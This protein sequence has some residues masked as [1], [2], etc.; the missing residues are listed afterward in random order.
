ML[1]RIT[2][3][4]RIAGLLFVCLLLGLG[5]V[6][7]FTRATG[8]AAAQ[9]PLTSEPQSGDRA[10]AL[11]DF[12]IRAGLDRSLSAPPP[13]TTETASGALAPVLQ[14]NAAPNVPAPAAAE[15]RFSSLTRTP[16]KL[17]SLRGTLTPPRQTNAEDNAL[18]TRRFLKANGA[19]FRLSTAEV[20]GLSVARH[21]EDRHNGAAHVTLAQAVNGIEVFQG[22]FTAH[23]DRAGALVAA[24]GELM[25]SLKQRVNRA[26]PAVS[27]SEAVRLASAYAGVALN[28][29]LEQAQ[30]ATGQNARQRF[31]DTAALAR[32]IEAKLVYFPLTPDE[33]RLAWQLEFWRRDTQDVYLIMLDAERGS[34]LYRRNLTWREQSQS[35]PRGQVYTKDSPRPGLPQG[36][37]NPAVV[38]R[39]ELAFQP[40]P[41]NGQPVFAATDPH[42][43][44]WAGGALT[45][46][47]SNNTDTHLDRD[48]NNQP[49]TPRLAAVNGN[50]IFP[51]DL[52]KAPTE[53]DNQ[54]AAQANLFYWVN[55][56]HDIMYAYGFTEAAGNFQ[57]NNFNL[58]GRAG[59]PI[60]AQA[61]DGGG[62]N[63]ANFS[64]GA[65]GSTARVQM[66]LW[67][68]SPQIDGSLDQGIII[69]EL[70][71]GLSIRLV[72][73]G[74]GLTGV[75]GGG[76]GEGWSDYFGLVLLRSAGDDLDASY[77]VGQ[78]A[79]NNYRLGIRR[80]PYSTDRNIFPLTFGDLKLSTEVHN[81]GE[82]WCNTLLEM[83]ALLIRQ[84]G[85][86]EGQRQS[87]QLVVD[88]LKLTP[89]APTFVDARNAILLADK[90]NN[91]G[92]NQCLLWQAFA[93]RG[94]GFSA[95]ALNALDGR[96]EEAFDAPPSCSAAGTLS[97][98]RA[99]FLLGETLTITL[100]DRNASAPARVRV[101]SSV[102][103]DQET[104]TLNADATLAGLFNVNVRLAA[105]AAQP[106]DGI[107]QASLAARDKLRVIY[108]DTDNGSGAAAQVTALAD[109]A[110]EKTVFE[111][112][113]EQGNR[114]WQVLG[115]PANWG[116]TAARVASGALAW[117]DSPSGNYPNNADTSL[118]SPV[119][120]FSNA[121][122]VTLSFAHSFA[123]E[124]GYDFGLVEFSLD[125]GVNWQRVAAYTGTQTGF[126]QMRLPLD[127][128]A[129]LARARLRFR[130]LTDPGVTG[131]G[132][133]LDDIRLI[134]RTADPA[135]LPPTV[136][137]APVITALLP[138]SGSPSGGTLVKLNGA[139]FT[140]SADTRVYFDNLLAANINVLS[141]TVLT[142]NVPAHPAGVATI[143]VENRYGAAVFTNGYTY[144]TRPPSLPTPTLASVQ[145]S[146]G[147]LR[148]GTNV[149][150]TGADFTPETTV[151][152]GAL[153]AAVTFVSANMLR[154]VT[155]SVT[156]SGTVDVSLSNPNNNK[157]TLANA[158]NYTAATPPVAQ[159][160]LPN[161]G[162]RFFNGNT[163]TLR[164][165]TSD[166]RAL[167]RH[168]L[169]LHRSVGQL[170][171]ALEKVGDLATDLPGTAQTFNWTIPNSLAPGTLYRLRVIA[172]DD[173]G[174]ET[175][176]FSS[177]DFTVERRWES[178]T[179]LPQVLQRLAVVT[180]GQAIFTIGGRTTTASTTTV[181]TVRKLDLSATPPQ[182]T[183]L[184]SLPLGL[185]AI[186]AAFLNGKLYV[187]GGF[188]IQAAS[189]PGHYVY[190][191]AANTWTRNGEAPADLM[192][193]A[194]VADPARGAYYLIGGLSISQGVPVNSVYAYELSS[195]TW[196][197]LPPL[198][199]ARFAHEAALVNGKLYVA[200]GSDNARSLAAAEVFD[201]T[202]QTWSPLAPL[203]RPRRYA[204]NGVG[205]DE[206]G[207]PIW[208][209]G[210]GEEANGLPPLTSVEAYDP[211]L[212]RWLT[213]D[214]S[215]NLPSTRTA[216]SGAV[217]N[218][219]LYAIGGGTASAGSGTNSNANERLK[220]ANTTLIQAN[221][222][223]LL[224]VPATQLAF[225]GAELKLPVTA[226]DFG[227]DMPLTLTAQGLPNGA[228]FEVTNNGNNNARGLLRWTPQA[229]DTGRTVSLSFTVNDGQLSDVKTVNLRVVTPTAL[230]AVGAADYRGGQLALDSIVSAFGTNLASRVETAQSLPLPLSLGDTT[231][232][233]NG[234]LAPLFFVSPTQ[235]NFLIPAPVDLGTAQI[236]VTN[237]AGSYALGTVEL[238]AARPAIFTANASGQG[239]AAA[240]ATPDGL[241][242]QTAPFDVQINGKPN[243]LILF[244]SGLRRAAADFPADANGVAEAVSVTIEGVSARV[245]FAG[246]QGGLAGLDQLNI[247]I[248]ASLAGKGARRVDVL[249]SVNGLSAN[250]V[251]IPLKE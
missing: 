218:G 171:P 20:D 128:L 190:D 154:A 191:I 136:T 44:W 151:S 46:L 77:P 177:A 39:E 231:V 201:F 147:S 82:I 157:T 241:S 182:W 210:A 112:N 67:S 146:A 69:H 227:A 3:L 196:R 110:G 59:D 167:T 225:V 102:T 249:V 163:I 84:F 5:C 114:G 199:T 111:D 250:R 213:L 73:N 180:D 71:H 178:S 63:N 126:N 4:H 212:N 68:G 93:K 215:F 246:A 45:S 117:T 15:M 56:Y 79:F 185:N 135:V 50:F 34:L 118:I 216:L 244:G 139:N 2:G 239:D 202:T 193:Y 214:N 25:P 104:V 159:V 189:E 158:F 127:K 99:A 85:F 31:R 17:W 70:T 168:R 101:E 200:G 221:Q 107:L 174:S 86:E 121:A 91:N 242:F 137:L 109:L 130:I 116:T 47:I 94:L 150:L 105:G 247:E 1:N 223:P 124:N 88:G 10:P 166:N 33:T 186:D 51:I 143:R 238:V 251:T 170:T 205:S 161:G 224:D 144:Y 80:F 152:F 106:G 235:I 92:A 133:Y 48:N 37:V 108:D 145:P 222:P 24:Q 149:V 142:V 195:N 19:L 229:S 141:N 42:F 27:A 138:A 90:L 22:E 240:I 134:V 169:E 89:N 122:G 156:A 132:W 228:Q 115:T 18:R 232:T 16:S 175:D 211:A 230:A 65:D 206:G 131:D 243:I 98:N 140:E 76:M 60:Q 160:V 35:V 153:S 198:Q 30:P 173:E 203:P 165:Q 179:A 184:A 209:V 7:W 14:L 237:A 236:L 8:R 64:T 6:S 75:H 245:L 41:F 29:T 72:G 226:N 172:V 11:P 120:D 219:N 197:T 233:V 162:E 97:L 12:D 125:E 62:T 13:E 57:T 74:L 100:G 81:V 164:W 123:F 32:A 181:N 40:A 66:Y 26:A 28:G 148:G 220:V 204:V 61:Q 23:Y 95:Q 187:P 207:R 96:P 58:G 217:V 43:D 119:F 53:A 55:R 9:S 36:P 248:P 103:G 176:T 234:V 78:Y 188:T 113:V 54:A 155:P 208:F 87:I 49:D 183:T 129:G 192:H 52:S 194:T 21:Y 83:R 38:S